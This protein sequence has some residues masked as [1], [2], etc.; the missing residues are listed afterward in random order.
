MNKSEISKSI[1]QL[2]DLLSK[3]HGVHKSDDLMEKLAI[4]VVDDTDTLCEVVETREGMFRVA[5]DEVWNA[6][7]MLSR[8]KE[9]EAQCQEGLNRT[10]NS[11]Y[12]VMLHALNKE[13]IT[14]SKYEIAQRGINLYRNKP[15][16]ETAMHGAVEIKRRARH[17]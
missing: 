4:I 1:D 11:L 7:R 17:E 10:Y 2:S 16:M 13:K 14:G 15:W 5:Q 6:R 9:V 12:L 8:A 3:G